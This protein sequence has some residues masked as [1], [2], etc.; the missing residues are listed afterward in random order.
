MQHLAVFAELALAVSVPSVDGTSCNP[1]VADAVV[2]LFVLEMV[3]VKTTVACATLAARALPRHADL[4]A[5][6]RR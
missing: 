5:A 1:D 4:V 2:E 3:S 6:T